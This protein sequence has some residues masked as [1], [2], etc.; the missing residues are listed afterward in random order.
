MTP[1][2]PWLWIALAGGAAATLLGVRQLLHRGLAPGASTEGATPAQLGL[3]AQAVQI[4]GAAGQLFAWYL[5][6]PVSASARAS[7]AVL[8]HGWGGNASTLLAAA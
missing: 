1:A 3:P 5:P 7:A 2:L 6:A 4:P 8:L